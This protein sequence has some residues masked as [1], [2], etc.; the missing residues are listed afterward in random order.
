MNDNQAGPDGPDNVPTGRPCPVCGGSQR[1]VLFHQSFLGVAGSALI[2]R[3]DVALCEVC[4]MAYATGI[5]LQTEFDEFYRSQSKYEFQHRAGKESKHDEGRLR[6]TASCIRPYVPALDSRILEIGSATGRLLALL[7]GSGYENV[8]GLDPSPA[9]AAAALA[10]YG[11]EVRTNSLFELEAEGPA[12]D[13]IVLNCVLEHIEAVR[14]ALSKVKALLAPP[15]GR[16]F[17]VVPDASRFPETQDSPFQEFSNEHINFFSPASLTNLMR[18]L[19]FRELGFTPCLVDSQARVLSPTLLAAYQLDAAAVSAPV[20]DDATGASLRR[21]IEMCS[22][23]DA[24]MRS[25][26]ARQATGGQSIIVWGTG[27][28]TQRLLAT[29]GL[30]GVSIAAYA[31]SNPKSWGKTLGGVPILAPHDLAARPEPILISSR[32][33]QE[34]ILGQIDSL[35]LRNRVILLY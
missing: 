32:G 1:E 21:Y 3:Y 12:F 24:D 5:P 16:V 28:H 31:D 10:L 25:K 19:G 23:A 8:S 20:H 15:G 7:K 26:I 27:T 34:E 11:V 30:D 18:T 6:L 13:L 22:Q 33:F 29:G 14:P 2:D 17:L 4:G 9:C 35:Q